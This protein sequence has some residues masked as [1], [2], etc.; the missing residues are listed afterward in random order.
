MIDGEPYDMFKDPITDDGGKRSAKGRLAV[1]Q[2]ENGKYFLIQQATPAQEA[3]S[4][5]RP[6]WRD[7][8]FLHTESFD[9]IRARARQSLLVSV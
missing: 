4:L 3:T 2:D 9:V 5:L 8:Q 6:V 7:G 1:H